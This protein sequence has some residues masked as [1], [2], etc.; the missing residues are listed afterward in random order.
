MTCT[1]ILAVETST[2]HVRLEDRN[3]AV[4]T[5]PIGVN[6]DLVNEKRHVSSMLTV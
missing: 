4:G 3:V 6:M 5:F 2:N 1:R